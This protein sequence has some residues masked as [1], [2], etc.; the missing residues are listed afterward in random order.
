MSA[1]APGG[2]IEWHDFAI[3][4]FFAVTLSHR[5]LPS[6][7][8]VASLLAIYG[9]FAIGL[10]A[11]PLGGLVFGYI[12]DRLGGRRVL[13]LSVIAMGAATCLRFSGV[14]ALRRPPSRPR[15]RAT[16][17]PARVRS[18]T[19]L[20]SNSASAPNMWK[21]RRPPLELVSSAP[22]AGS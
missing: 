1:S 2:V 15:A 6:D 5:F 10:L 3:C 17:N 19:R 14:S 13:I 9:I 11:R 8:P 21:I 20:R 4:G 7:D 12:G 16:C 22:H 18:R